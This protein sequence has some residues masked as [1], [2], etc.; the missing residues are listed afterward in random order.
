[1]EIEPKLSL[2]IGFL[3]EVSGKYFFDVRICRYLEVGNYPLIQIGVSRMGVEESLFW[4]MQLALEAI[5]AL[6][7]EDTE[8]PQS[9]LGGTWD[10]PEDMKLDFVSSP[11]Y[12]DPVTYVALSVIPW[13]TPTFLSAL[14]VYIPAGD[15]YTA[16]PGSETGYD[17]EVLPGDGAIFTPQKAKFSDDY[18]MFSQRNPTI[19]QSNFTW[20]GQMFFNPCDVDDE[21]IILTYT[22]SFPTSTDPFSSED[23]VRYIQ[24][25]DSPLYG[26]S[27]AYMWSGPWYMAYT[28]RKKAGGWDAEYYPPRD[29]GEVTGGSPGL[30]EAGVSLLGLVGGDGLGILA[31]GPIERMFRKL[32]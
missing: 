20:W 19:D 32:K 6:I 29:P 14:A 25:C 27:L 18:Y 11:V 4:I 28:I 3:N 10:A 8:F 21:H 9:L 12:V 2:W 23:E 26:Y 13:T 24:F 15:S 30:I 1:M 17:K 22:S 16:I 7:L 5:P 31:G